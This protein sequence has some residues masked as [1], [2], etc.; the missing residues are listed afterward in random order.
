MTENDKVKIAK[1][2]KNAEFLLERKYK[3]IRKAVEED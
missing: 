1:K 3:A 2:R